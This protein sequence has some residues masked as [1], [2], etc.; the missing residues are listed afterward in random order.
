MKKKLVYLVQV[1]GNNYIYED[2]E[3]AVRIYSILSSAD[4]FG[5]IVSKVSIKYYE[6]L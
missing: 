3:K 6:L 1:D 5:S 2:K 4:F